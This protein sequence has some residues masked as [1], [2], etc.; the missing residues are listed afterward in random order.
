MRQARRSQMK[1]IG[2]SARNRIQVRTRLMIEY[3]LNSRIYE[4]AEA[5]KCRL[6]VPEDDSSS[7]KNLKKNP[8]SMSGGG[9][10]KNILQFKKPASDNELSN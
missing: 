8:A 1:A 6:F 5:V 7:N 4:L 3:I 10:G 9:H 2:K